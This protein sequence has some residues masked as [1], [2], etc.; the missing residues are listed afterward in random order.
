[1]K[2]ACEYRDLAKIMSFWSS[3]GIVH[4]L[5]G[6]E[7]TSSAHTSRLKALAINGTVSNR[8]QF[9]FTKIKEDFVKMI[10]SE[11]DSAVVSKA[12]GLCQAMEE[13]VFPAGITR[14]SLV[15]M[16]MEISPLYKGSLSNLVDVFMSF[17]TNLSRSPNYAKDREIQDHIL[18]LITMM[19]YL[20][21]SL[22]SLIEV[23][24]KVLTERDFDCFRSRKAVVLS[25]SDMLKKFL[26]TATTVDSVHQFFCENAGGL[27]EK[28]KCFHKMYS[29]FGPNS[30]TQQLLEKNQVEIESLSAEITK[31]RSDA[32]KRVG[33]FPVS[34]RATAQKTD[35]EILSI[36]TQISSIK[37]K[38][39]NLVQSIERAKCSREE[40][41]QTEDA[42][43]DFI[44]NIFK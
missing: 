37:V 2:Y 6:F 23:L 29:S 40:T 3:C 24:T 8:C 25:P 27:E 39:E 17:L 13:G 10:E 12:L 21:I 26:E 11:F 35:P 16:F 19:D 20:K 1:V 34:R 32:T 42:F 28:F 36:N 18:A 41:P 5:S 38:I 22:R 4:F 43:L 15:K 30:Q 7:F 14:S 33:T 31:L 44:R 9:D